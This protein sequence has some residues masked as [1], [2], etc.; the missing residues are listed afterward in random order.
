MSRLRH[1]SGTA[2]GKERN[3]HS[4]SSVERRDE[5]LRSLRDALR[6]MRQGDFA[7]RLPTDADARD[8]LDVRETA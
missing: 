5:R 1:E 3:G 8:V 4:A 2:R 7:V 6:A